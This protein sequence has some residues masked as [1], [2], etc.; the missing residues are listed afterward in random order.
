M[1]RDDSSLTPQQFAKVR[2]EARRALRESGAFGRFPTPVHDIMQAAKLEEVQE[3]VLNEG[4]LATMRRKA[5]KALKSA[6]SKVIGLFDVK[7]RLVFID[8]TLYAAKQTFVRLHET[9]HGFMPWQKD[10]YAVIEECD[11]TIDPGT[12][13]LFDREANAFAAEVLFQIDTFTEEAQ[14]KPFGI[15]APVN[16]HKKYGASIYAAVRQYVSKNHRACMVLVI[17]PPQLVEGEGLS[18][19]L[20][21]VVASARFT[22]VFGNLE[23]PERFTPSDRIGAMIPV[24]KGRR[25][26]GKRTIRL[27]DRNGDTQNCV[28]EA[29][30]QGYQV[31]ILIHAVGIP[32]GLIILP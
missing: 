30:T 12:A 8:R 13:D 18:A 2:A 25:M 31:F 14:G 3:D 20:R 16:L 1:K 32:S 19:E 29:F 28:A 7:A 21:R 26:S 6:L 24:G 5:G 9:A 10:L 22:E 11:Q 4:F 23:W 17:D 15:L 27:D